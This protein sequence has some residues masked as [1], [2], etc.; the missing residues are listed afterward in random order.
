MTDHTHDDEAPYDV[1]RDI[2]NTLRIIALFLLVIGVLL[3]AI[4]FK[5]AEIEVV[6]V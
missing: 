2:R 1:Q 5:F 3:A 4:V 6:P